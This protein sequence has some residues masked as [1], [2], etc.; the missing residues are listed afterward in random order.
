MFPVDVQCWCLA[1]VNEPAAQEARAYDHWM[2]EEDR[3]ARL[4]DTWK[5]QRCGTIQRRWK[6]PTLDT[7][8]AVGRIR[9]ALAAH[10]H[11]RDT[12]WAL[13]GQEH[14]TCQK[15]WMQLLLPALQWLV[16]VIPSGKYFEEPCTTLT[17]HQVN[18]WLDSDMRPNE[19]TIRRA[20]QKHLLQE[21]IIQEVRDGYQRIRDVFEQAG[22]YHPMKEAQPRPAGIFPC[23]VCGQIFAQAQKLQ[24]HRWSKHSLISQERMFVYG[25]VC[26]SCGVNFW[27]P[28]RVQQHLRS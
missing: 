24:V 8:L 12:T 3:W 4:L 25:P 14:E 19:A 7:R 23:D 18:E 21:Q 28:Q 16:D 2:A 22:L 17:F 15:S 5:Y 9:F 6:L 1:P 20:L 10:R 27:T 11:A 26:I 13:I